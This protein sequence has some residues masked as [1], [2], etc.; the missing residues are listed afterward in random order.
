M[1]PPLRGPRVGCVGGGGD[2]TKAPREVV[3]AVCWACVWEEEREMHIA[4]KGREVMPDL[5]QEAT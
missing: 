1:W 3:G 4:Q 2:G 5:D